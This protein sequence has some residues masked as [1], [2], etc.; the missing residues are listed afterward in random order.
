MAKERSSSIG[1]P[2]ASSMAG[3]TVSANDLLPNSRSATS[4]ASGMPGTSAH[5]IPATG[6][7]S[8]IPLGSGGETISSA[9]SLWLRKKSAVASLG[10]VPT[11]AMA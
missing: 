2:S 5:R 8:F 11:P 9:C 1:K 3:S 4:A 10:M 7:Q 6:T